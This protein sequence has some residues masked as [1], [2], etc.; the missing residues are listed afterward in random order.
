MPYRWRPLTWK[1]EDKEYVNER[2][3]GTQQTG[4]SFVAQSRQVA[5]KELGGIIW[6]G[7]D[8]TASSVYAPMYR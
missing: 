5:H 6:F 3:V 2:S 8:D 1:Y 4:F 7:V